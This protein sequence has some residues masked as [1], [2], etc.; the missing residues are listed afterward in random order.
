MEAVLKPGLYALWTVFH[1]VRVEVFDAHAVRFEHADLAV[2]AQTDLVCALPARF[3]A[4][5][6]AR[7]GLVVADA[8][9]PLGSFQLTAVVP[10]VAMMD[11][12]VAWFVAQLAASASSAATLRPRAAGSATRAAR[13]VAR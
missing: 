10:E 2:I 13:A 5:H 8:P 6:A 9:L 1:Q 11:A 3:A 12:G 7:F 4:A